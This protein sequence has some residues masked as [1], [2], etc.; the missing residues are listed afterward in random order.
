MRGAK[1]ELHSLLMR[2][3]RRGTVG[4]MMSE[5][6]ENMFFGGVAKIHLEARKRMTVT[7]RGQADRAAETGSSLGQ[8]GCSVRSSGR[9]DERVPQQR[10][11]C[12]TGCMPCST[13]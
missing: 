13:G 6:T 2:A 11:R 4:C 8:G 5:Q 9:G 3:L 12:R 1:G 10:T 7:A